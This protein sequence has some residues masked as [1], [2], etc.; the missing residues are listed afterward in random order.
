MLYSFVNSNIIIEALSYY[1]LSKKR[2]KKYCKQRNSKDQAAFAD[3]DA[4]PRSYAVQNQHGLVWRNRL[5]LFRANPTANFDGNAQC[6]DDADYYTNVVCD[7]FQ[8][9][10]CA[11]TPHIRTSFFGRRIIHPRRFND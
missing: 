3:R 2:E 1:L 4:H 10:V 7:N 8:N 11:T 5:Y 9:C 6:V